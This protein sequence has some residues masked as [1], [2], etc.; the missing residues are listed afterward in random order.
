MRRR[1][2]LAIVLV[3]ALAV[4]LFGIP[5]AVVL[6][7]LY[8]TN[9][10]ATLVREAT[11]SARDI[12]ADFANETDPID[13]PTSRAGI[14]VGLYTLDGHRLSGAGPS[15]A[16]VA[17]RDALAS[18]VADVEVG[19]RLVA[20]V[21]VAVNETVVAAVRAETSVHPAERRAY[22][23]WALMAM[24][25]VV[26]IA[27]AGALGAALAARLTRP[28]RRVSD[29]ATRL[30][31]GDFTITVPRT[32]VAELDDVGDALTT[33]ASRLGRAMEREQSFSTHASHQ[34]RT[35]IAGLRLTIETELADPR[36]DATLALHECLVVADRLESTVND[37]L[38]LSREPAADQHVDVTSVLAAA[39]ARWHG[40]LAASG[41]PLRIDTAA[42]LPQASAS[43]A[44]ITQALDV[45]V[46]NAMRHGRGEV[47]V[48]AERVGGGVVITVTDE[49][50]GNNGSAP[51]ATN[52]G[53]VDD[54]GIGL[55]L[56]RMLVEADG[57]RILL[58]EPGAPSTYSIVLR[59]ST[60]DNN[61]R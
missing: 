22:R 29:S 30:G 42:N 38:R 20:A 12:P 1:I 3:T 10:R 43:Q 26:V 25:G 41:R 50:N 52:A 59:A 48:R 21:P 31:H 4:A 57:G 36:T 23:A 61:D 46:D 45:L 55:G 17:V 44:A 28:L 47:S 11:L 14:A 24:L 34:L 9:A 53:R 58:P 49:G 51:R 18:R 35:P 60:S 19:D 2:T 13:L 40:L 27:L 56:A 5:L 33:T 39:E 32:G 16:D 15:E 54:H 6:R 37:L 8:I 7:H